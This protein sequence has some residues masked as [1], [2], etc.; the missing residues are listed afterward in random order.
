MAVQLG[1]TTKVIDTSEMC[2]MSV[3]SNGVWV[4]GG[5]CLSHWSLVQPKRN[6][7]SFFSFPVKLL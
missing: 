7:I 3:S 1:Q 2:N 5:R 6:V 4:R